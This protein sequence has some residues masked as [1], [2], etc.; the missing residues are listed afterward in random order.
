MT[1]GSRS[2]LYFNEIMGKEP[3]FNP[4]GAIIVYQMTEEQLKEFAYRVVEE[5]RD[6]V[7]EE[8]HRRVASA[9]GNRVEYCSMEEACAITGKSRQTL[10]AWVK[11]GR[12]HPEYNG[13]KILFLRKEVAKEAGI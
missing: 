1:D 11:K 13:N 7:A 8:L 5:T 9:M 12:L 6:S 3:L 2:C 10:Y 4:Q